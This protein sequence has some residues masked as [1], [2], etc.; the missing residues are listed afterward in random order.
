M[1]FGPDAEGGGQFLVRHLTIARH[2]HH[3]T[4]KCFL[5]MLPPNV[6]SGPLPE[7]MTKRRQLEHGCGIRSPIVARW[8]YVG[9]T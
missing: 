5:F 7:R 4:E 6:G 3:T 8:C 9:A 1:A 2:S